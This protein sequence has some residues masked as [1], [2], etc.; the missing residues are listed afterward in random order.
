MTVIGASGFIA[1][2]TD[3]SSKDEL[4]ALSAGIASGLF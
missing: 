2:L 1:T 3:V 4:I